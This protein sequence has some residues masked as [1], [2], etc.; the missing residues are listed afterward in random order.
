MKKREREIGKHIEA[1]A[2][3]SC[4]TA[5]EEECALS[6]SQSGCQLPQKDGKPTTSANEKNDPQCLS[7]KRVLEGVVLR[8]CSKYHKH[9]HHMCQTKD[10]EGKL[11]DDC[12]TEK[13]SKPAAAAH[14]KTPNAPVEIGVSYDRAG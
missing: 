1:V 13:S 3:A 10:E 7:C 6:S 5:L 14:G 8:K 11:C 2:K 9:Y 4:A 12:F